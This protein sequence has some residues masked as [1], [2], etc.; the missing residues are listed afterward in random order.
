MTAEPSSSDSVQQAFEYLRREAI[1][2]HLAGDGMRVL[3]ICTVALDRID[4]LSTSGTHSISLSDVRWVFFLSLYWMLDE[5]LTYDINDALKHVATDD[6]SSTDVKL[7]RFILTT[8]EVPLNFDAVDELKVVPTEWLLQRSR[9]CDDVAAITMAVELKWYEDPESPAWRELTTEWLERCPRPSLL[10]ME[11]RRTVQ[12]LDIQAQLRIDGRLPEDKLL[13]GDTNREQNLLIEA[14]RL[15][16]E[17]KFVELDDLVEKIVALVAVESPVYPAFF[18][19]LHFSRFERRSKESQFVSLSRRNYVESR[20][21]ALVCQLLRDGRF[22]SSYSDLA[23]QGFDDGLRSNRFTCF[24]MAMLNQLHALRSW[25]IGGWMF[26]ER[27]RSQALLEL[28]DRGHAEFAT[29]G[30][31]ALRNALSIPEPDKYPHFDKAIRVLDTLPDRERTSFVR[32]LL[33]SP[34]IAWVSARRVLDELSDAIP[35]V[36]LP[37]VA[38]WYVRLDLDEVHG[39]GTHTYLQMWGKVLL[40]MRDPVGV[41]DIL[42]PALAVKAR[43]P[44]CWDMLHGTFIAAITKGTALTAQ[45]ILSTLLD[46]PCNDHHFNQYRFSILANVVRRRSEFGEPCLVWMRRYAEERQDQYELFQLRNLATSDET[47]KDDPTFREW[48]RKGI[49]GSCN[50]LLAETGN[51]RHFG[52]LAYHAMMQSVTWQ[53]PEPDLVKALIDIVNAEHVLYVNK[54]DPI[55]CLAVLA[56]VGPTAQTE[57]ILGVAA[58][59]LDHGITGKDM[60][61]RGPLASFQFMG[62]GKDQAATPFAHL[63]D[64]LAE[65]HCGLIG[66]RLAKWILVEGIRR[67]P[68][69]AF[70]TIRTALHLSIGMRAEDEAL[71][72]ALLGIAEAAAH[73]AFSAEPRVAVNGFR[74]LVLNDAPHAD[75]AAWLSSTA[76]ELCIEMW[77][78]RLVEASRL[79]DPSARQA[80]AFTIFDWEKSAIPLPACLR[81]VR[82]RLAND[83]RL[84]V[85]SAISGE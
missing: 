68:Q 67:P 25:D 37:D 20:Q 84:R 40:R 18:R 65:R 12:R 43:N 9:E 3:H 14:W 6:V 51:R 5:W 23:R 16:Y 54:D 11:L 39:R 60:G 26:A 64:A 17:A 59:W 70:H 53:Q 81:E 73:I 50:T 21:P 66:R 28:C 85:R 35:D 24:R 58:G 72:M 38:A 78:Q 22:D 80:V 77:Q 13:H 33:A 82:E 10:E 49:A 30:I 41:I 48:L 32:N 19:V 31:I 62:M 57:T 74:T 69:L 15:Y 2:A 29:D 27:Q 75:L 63:L 71:S 1:D 52:T 42:K 44:I 76:G 36:D 83:C 55:R 45:Q 79:P 47:P 56:S 46:A 61:Q 8:L 7:I 4:R 34:R